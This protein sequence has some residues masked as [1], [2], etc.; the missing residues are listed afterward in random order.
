MTFDI[1]ADKHVPHSCKNPPPGCLSSHVDDGI[2]VL[3]MDHWLYATFHSG[4]VGYIESFTSGCRD[5]HLTFE[6][7]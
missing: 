3:L 7:I 6:F 1:N 4:I 2:N 5:P